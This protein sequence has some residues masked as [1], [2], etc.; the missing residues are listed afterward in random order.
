MKRR[1]YVC[2]YL[3]ILSLRGQLERVMTGGK[4][5]KSPHKSAHAC[6]H[7]TFNDS[8]IEGTLNG[9]LSYIKHPVAWSTQIY[10]IVL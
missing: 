6:M 2:L 10:V 5:D 1:T 9:D 8:G 3:Y 4:L 7:V